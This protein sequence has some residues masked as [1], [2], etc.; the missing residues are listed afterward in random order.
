MTERWYR[1]H[2]ARR[3]READ[4]DYS[5]MLHIFSAE[6]GKSIGYCDITPHRRED[7]Q[8]VRIGYTIFNNHW[9]R[10]FVL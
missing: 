4:A 2:L 10:A 5:Y 6:D 8:Y 3:Q 9:G 1:E 7:F